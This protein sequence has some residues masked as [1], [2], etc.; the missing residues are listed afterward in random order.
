[1]PSHSTCRSGTASK[2][3]KVQ[4]VGLS[5]AAHTQPAVVR[6]DHPRRSDH[7]AEA[8][9]AEQP[10]APEDELPRRE[11][12]EPRR[13]IV[14]LDLGHPAAG[15]PDEY[16]ANGLVATLHEVCGMAGCDRVPGE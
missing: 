12:A 11:V 2:L 4:D 14:E 1:M 9:I 13:H 15:V 10:A 16:D 8:V 6:R 3:A 5:R 7:C